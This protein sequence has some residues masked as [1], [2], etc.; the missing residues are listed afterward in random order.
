MF[1]K[2]CGTEL[3]DTAKFCPKCG[4]KVK[5]VEITRAEP[6]S[7]DNQ[8]VSDEKLENETVSVEEPVKNA[9][10][11]DPVQPIEQVE[12]AKQPEYPKVTH[13]V[14]TDIPK[15]DVIGTAKRLSKKSI[16]MFVTLIVLAVALFFGYRWYMN[17]PVNIKA[18]DE[19]VENYIE[20]SGVSGRGEVVINYEGLLDDLYGRISVETKETTKLSELATAKQYMSYYTTLGD[21][22]SNLCNGDEVHLNFKSNKSMDELAG[23]NITDKGY[24]Y[25][26]SGLKE[27]KLLDLF[28]DIQITSKKEKIW[29]TTYTTYDVVNNSSDPILKNFDYDVTDKGN[30]MFTVR[31][32]VSETELNNLGYGVDMTDDTIVSNYGGFEKVYLL[33]SV[34]DITPEETPQQEISDGKIGSIVCNVNSLNIRSSASTNGSKLGKLNTGDTRDV[35]E[36]KTGEGYTWYRIGDGQWVADDGTWLTYT[37]K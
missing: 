31:C 29:G 15:T 35:Y 5:K 30:G 1:C 28:K 18:F 23:L 19:N 17:R 8:V 27:V 10:P 25:T 4:T 26:V 13:T 3:K 6:E 7:V 9:Q 32:N 2:N 20:I 16:A 24:T 33:D 11:A 14:N 34:V 22:T 12:K 21:K 36:Q 37:A